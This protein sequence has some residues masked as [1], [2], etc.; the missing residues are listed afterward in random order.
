M[1]EVIDDPWP[2]LLLAETHAAAGKKKQAL[3]DLQK[4]VQRGL[5]DADV[6]DSDERLQVLKVEPEFQKLLAELRQK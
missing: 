6:I 4:A 2:V 3:N 5:K 1:A